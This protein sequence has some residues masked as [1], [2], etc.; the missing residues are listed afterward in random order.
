[1][2]LIYYPNPIFKQKAEPVTHFDLTLT[3][4][5]HIMQAALNDHR[6]IGIGANMC[7]ILQRIIIVP[8]NDQA[9]ST[10]KVIMINPQITDQS[11]AKQNFLEA[12]LSL[13][14][15]EA[16]ITRPETITVTYQ[17]TDQNHHER[18]VSGFVATVIQHE[19]DYLN[20]V[21]YLDYLPKT[22]AKLLRDKMKKYL[23]KIQRH[24]NHS[25]HPAP[26]HN[27][28]HHHHD[29]NCCDHKH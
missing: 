22:K 14:G 21:V 29:G 18:T 8:S 4:N 20:G 13:P 1:M 12:S 28:D 10:D 9:E 19:I 5:I 15:I 6:A 16:M 11:D 3:K 23:K 25:H 24:G 7:G 26:H 2:S 17:D 27:H